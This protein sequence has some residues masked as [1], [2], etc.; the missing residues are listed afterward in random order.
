MGWRVEWWWLCGGG[1]EECVEVVCGGDGV[2][3]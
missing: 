2:G 3:F 1:G